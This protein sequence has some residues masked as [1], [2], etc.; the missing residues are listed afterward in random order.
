[1]T[2]SVSLFLT[3][4]FNEECFVVSKIKKQQG[5]FHL[6]VVTFHAAQSPNAKSMSLT[7]ALFY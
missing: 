2:P 4:N 1:M 6:F 7:Y 3:I 5:K